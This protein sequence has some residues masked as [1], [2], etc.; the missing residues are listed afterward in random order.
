MFK[1]G[2][3]EKIVL[4]I[5]L[6]IVFAITILLYFVLRNKSDRIKNIP[7]TLIAS[8][9]IVMEIIKQAFT[10]SNI[11]YDLWNMPFHFCSMFMLWFAIA[12]FCTGRAKQFGQSM[13]FVF[14][15]W[16]LILFYFD[17]QSVIG[18]SCNNVFADYGSFHTFFYHHFVFL[19]LFLMIALK[20]YVPQKKDYFNVLIGYSTF[21]VCDLFFANALNINY[22]NLLYSDIGFM[23]QFRVNSG[24]IS[25]LLLMFIGG[26]LVN[27]IF[28]LLYYFIF[29]L[30]NNKKVQ[31]KL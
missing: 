6:A 2:P 12:Q 23:E 7:L 30:M 13:S 9:L 26:I 21:F 19:F 3:S 17:P 16:L 15:V 22:T 31:T 27:V 29:K 11:P 14:G 24:Q 28:I 20:T 8:V 18:P 25:Y 4:P 10:F 1:Y 5:A